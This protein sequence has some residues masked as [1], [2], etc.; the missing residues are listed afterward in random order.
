MSEQIKFIVQ[1]LNKEPFNRKLNLI[2]FDS[3][4]SEHLLQVLNDV[5]AEIDLRVK[6]DV[7]EEDPEQLAVKMLGFLRILKYKPPPDVDL[8]EFRQGIVYGEKAVIH[9][10]LEWVLRRLEELKKR[11]YLARYLVK[12]ELAPAVEGDADVLELY[13]QYEQLIEDF[14]E[15]H[16]Q[17]EALK[18]SGF[19]PQEIRKDL[20]HMEE[21]REQLTKKIERVKRKVDSHPNKDEMLGIARNLR[22]EHDRADYLAKQ[23]TDQRNGLAHAEKT[24]QRL[25]Q[26]VKEL[27]H[28]ALGATPEGLIQ[29]LEEEIRVNS[30]LVKEKLP[31]EIN[32][33]QKYIKDLQHVVNQP[34]MG[35]SDIDKLNAKIKKVN[36]EVNQLIEKKMA[37]SEPV[38]DKLSLFRQQAA[39]IAR[40]KETAAE[41]LNE[42]RTE[43]AQL[44]EEL[45][46]K[47][48]QTKGF[49]G[50]EVLKGDEFKKYVTKLR[51]KS[52]LYKKKK[53]ELSDLRAETGVLA[54]TKEILEQR[55][56]SVSESLSL[57]E[58]QKGIGGFHSTQEELEKVSSV[59]AQLDEEKGH[60]LEEMSTMVRR[61]NARIN[62][63]K[64][65]LAPVI[66][67]LR[68]LRQ[69]CQDLK[70]EYDQKKSAY[71]SQSA[72]LESN[73]SKLEQEVQNLREEVSAE[74]SR[75]H[76]LNAAV[77]ILE[78]QQQSMSEELKI[79]VSSDSQE[80]KKSL[81]EQYNKRIQEQESQAKMLRDQQKEVRDNHTGSQHQVKM[82]NDLQKL[83]ECK[84]QCWE[85]TGTRHRPGVSTAVSGDRLVL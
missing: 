22:E 85:N 36:T 10:I 56:K 8:S 15:V 44:E 1:E 68:P 43:L 39:M 13:Q 37:S 76:Y 82:W 9:H 55:E 20:G 48:E 51:S 60:T 49:D 11:A 72:G 50:E 80:R 32:V 5:F 41:Q 54:R 61:I 45:Q 81:R 75:Y 30:Y 63:K 83:L 23:K 27:R 64:A 58:D 14:K 73:L 79:Y 3:L 24:I 34:A 19:S 40:K 59:K 16:K 67:E 2:S 33:R 28:A 84:K 29:K 17:Y 38:N 31:K 26:Q 71:D 78:E 74:E 65:H 52:T 6:V 57:L 46:E 62:E 35:Q 4:K 25:N 69:Q 7:R 12:I 21:E 47:R 42:V 70:Y 53:Q 77:E 18:T 66:K